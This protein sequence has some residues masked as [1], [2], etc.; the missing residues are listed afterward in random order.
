MGICIYIHMHIIFM[1]FYYSRS[2]VATG[3]ECVR[4]IRAGTSINA[5][6]LMLVYNLTII[7]MVLHE[8][9]KYFLKNDGWKMNILFKCS[10][11]R[12][13]VNYPGVYI[14]YRDFLPMTCATQRPLVCFT[15]VGSPDSP[16]RMKARNCWGSQ[17]FNGEIMA[18]IEWKWD[19]L[20]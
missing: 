6:N 11:F 8:K 18:I 4:L 19:E 12:G 16:V 7:C 10:F 3:C 14:A 13:H 17:L 1:Y 2:S 20:G 5:M 9:S 15:P